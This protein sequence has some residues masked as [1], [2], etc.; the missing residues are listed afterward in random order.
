MDKI[1]WKV[2]INNP[3]WWAQIALSIFTPIIGYMGL[4]LSDLTSW[5]IIGDVILGAISNPYVLIL[6]G[7]SLFNT[8]NDPTTKG[9]ADSKRAQSYEVPN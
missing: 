9:L 2:R 7:V 3:I 1:N 5:N 6:I 4:A 8:I